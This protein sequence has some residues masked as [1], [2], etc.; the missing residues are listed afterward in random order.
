VNPQS[1][2][3]LSKVWVTLAGA[4][5]PRTHAHARTHTHTHKYGSGDA[6]VR[7]CIRIHMCKHT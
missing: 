3:D 5:T 2:T 7:E 1:L 4:R 6:C